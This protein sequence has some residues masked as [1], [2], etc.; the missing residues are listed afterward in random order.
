[1]K[2]KIFTLV[3]M[4]AMVF[5][6]SSAWAQGN[7]QNPYPGGTYSYNLNGIYTSVTNAT[8]TLAWTGMTQTATVTTTHDVVTANEVYEID[9]M[10]D[11]IFDFSITYNM[12]ETSGPKT[13]RVTIK[14]GATG[15]ENYITLSINVQTPPT[16]ALQIT[17]ATDIVCQ[18][19]GT[20]ANNEN[21]ATP[22][23]GTQPS[24]NQLTFVITPTPST[25]VT[26][27]TYDFHIE[28]GD[29]AFGATPLTVYSVASAI[30]TPTFAA[31]TTGYDISG[32]SGATT[33]V[34][35]FT[36]TPNQAQEDFAAVISNPV[37]TV[38]SVDYTTGNTITD[39]V[40]GTNV[41]TITFMPAIGTFSF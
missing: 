13:L 7:A 5:V 17:S 8:A 35:R 2:Q 15:C 6:A 39:P 27:Y 21:A 16:I 19:L 23:I 30:G 26:T 28:L 22:I 1:M 33:V 40:A 20:P 36:T 3:L 38:S 29:W 31:G 34:V 14:D 37:L 18:N 9:G 12:N 25:G 24:P 4:L 10:N 32:A 41:S 11:H